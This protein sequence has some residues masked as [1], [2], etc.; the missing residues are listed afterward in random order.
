MFALVSQFFFMIGLHPFSGWSE[1]CLLEWLLE[2]IRAIS[3][4][5]ERLNVSSRHLNSCTTGDVFRSP[6]KKTD[7]TY[8]RSG[9][10]SPRVHLNENKTKIH[11]EKKWYGCLSLHAWPHD[12]YRCV[13]VYIF[14]IFP[15]YF[16]DILPSKLAMLL[17]CFVT[18]TEN[19]T[20]FASL[21]IFVSPGF[22]HVAGVCRG[23]VEMWRTG[24]FSCFRILWA[25]SKGLHLWKFN[26]WN[27]IMEVCFRDIF[28]SFH[29]W[30]L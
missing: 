5:N 29:G 30:W 8:W 17:Q 11:S 21:G 12:I 20:D 9:I 16:F 27:I 19:L 28:L 2:R 6:L 4:G 13:C 3:S 1:Y 22:A 7:A 15:F 10:Q 25:N 18:P 23:A 24:L 26:G 14:S